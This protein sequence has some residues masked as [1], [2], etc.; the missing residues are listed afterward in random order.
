MVLVHDGFNSTDCTE[1][2]GEELIRGSAAEKN[3][4]KVRHSGMVLNPETKRYENDTRGLEFYSSPH[5]YFKTLIEK[6]EDVIF[7]RTAKLRKERGTSSKW[8]DDDDESDP[9]I[10]KLKNE[11]Q[12]ILKSE[13]METER[14][15]KKNEK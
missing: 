9:V 1:I 7:K 12:S 15:R 6:K 4:F 8:G 5:A 2:N 10:L 3:L 11:L 14:W 13:L